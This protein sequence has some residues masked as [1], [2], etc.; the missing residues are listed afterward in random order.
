VGEE[1]HFIPAHQTAD[2]QAAL[3]KARSVTVKIFDRASGGA[4]H[5]QVGDLSLV[6]AATFKWLLTT[7]WLI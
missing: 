3:V 5:C 7:F 4:E 6:R 1:D 2:L